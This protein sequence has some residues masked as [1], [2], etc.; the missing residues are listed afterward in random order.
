MTQ[1][2]KER[3]ITGMIWGSV[4]RFG[5]MTISF[6]ANLVLARLL[7]PQDF[8]IIGMLMVFIALAD[9]LV[10]GGFASA[11]IQKKEPTQQD[12]STVFYWNLSASVILYVVLYFS[13]PA[14]AAFYN[15]PL[16][17]TVLRVQGLVLLFNAFNIIQNNQ[18]IKQL[19]FKRLAKVNIIAT[20]VG[21]VVGIVMAFA[22]FGVWSL[23]AKMLIKSI[24]TS[25]ILWYGSTWRLYNQ[26]SLYSF[27]SLFRFGSLM[28]LSSFTDTL[29]RQLQSLLIGR[30]F[31]AQD[32]GFY[33]QAR[34]LH[35][36]PEQ[37]IPQVVDQVMFPVY[38]SIQDDKEKVVGAIKKSLKVLVFINF[39]LMLLLLV[40]AEPLVLL[41][42]S[43][44]WIDSVLYFQIF[45]LGGMLYSLN[46]NNINVIK[47]LGKSNYILIALIIKRF[48]TILFVFIGL[49]FGI[50][51]VAA[52]YTL[53]IYVWFPINAY[54]T[55]KLINYGIF[56]QLKDIGLNYI[57][58]VLTA[59]TTI[60][61]SYYIEMHY[62]FKMIIET[63]LFT[64]IYFAGAWILSVDGYKTF[65]EITKSKLKS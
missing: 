33:T 31:S 48:I 43:D 65:I 6:I 37:A 64:T 46:S 55:N 2:L 50:L 58:A 8:G 23:V 14:I 15:M 63:L 59:L 38:S 29:V 27:K 10:N 61:F 26:F 44:K 21:A 17:N 28:L 51:G 13:A 12:Y 16:L 57:L 19:N 25:I 60:I 54:Y 7:S 24:A 34:S 1:S 3:T 56:K 4:Q 52:G 53:S 32:L 5:T 20:S 42:L 40:I 41:L 30:V 22:G 62:F 18:L 49:Q 39:P 45:C 11:L 9:T 47:S 35:S 36:I